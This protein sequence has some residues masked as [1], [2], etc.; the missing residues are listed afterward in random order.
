MLRIFKAQKL[1]R[2]TKGKRDSSTATSLELST[3]RKGHSLRPRCGFQT[4]R[5]PA[6]R[7]GPTQ[8]VETRPSRRGLRRLTERMG[9][10]K[11]PLPQQPCSPCT[12]IPPRTAQFPM[13]ITSLVECLSALKRRMDMLE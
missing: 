4:G 6:H 10:L 12:F 3:T 13:V 8:E 9:R 7:S 2:S 1:A 5:S 11:H